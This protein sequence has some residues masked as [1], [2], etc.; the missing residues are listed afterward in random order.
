MVVW[1]RWEEVAAF[2]QVVVKSL[3]LVSELDLPDAHSEFISSWLIEGDGVDFPGL[4][5]FL[6]YGEKVSYSLHL[7]SLEPQLCLALQVSAETAW[8]QLSEA[9]QRLMSNEL[10]TADFVDSLVRIIRNQCEHVVLAM[11]AEVS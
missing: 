11:G 7:P 4:N 6:A 9:I 1:C 5:F 3:R 8:S 10:S 2:S